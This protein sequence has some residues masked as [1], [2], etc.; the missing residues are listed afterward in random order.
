MPCGFRVQERQH[1]AFRSRPDTIHKSSLINS[2]ISYGTVCEFVSQHGFSIISLLYNAIRVIIRKS[3]LR[4]LISVRFEYSISMRIPLQWLRLGKSDMGGEHRT[5]SPSRR[6]YSCC[7]GKGQG[8]Q[9]G[10]PRSI[11][12]GVRR[13]SNIPRNIASVNSE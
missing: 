7:R 11:S 9:T 10:G 1:A 4:T 13:D 5:T 8:A 3:N 2:A 12:W 6:S